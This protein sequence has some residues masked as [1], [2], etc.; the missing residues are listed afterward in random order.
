MSVVTNVMITG[1]ETGRWVDELNHWLDQRDDP[2]G[3]LLQVD[4]HCG[5]PKALET[6]VFLAA[7]NHF[8]TPAF[9]AKCRETYAQHCMWPE[10]VQLYIQ[11][12]EENRWRL[13]PLT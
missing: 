4:Q 13:I 9:I 3:N 5:G 8:D 2:P 6:E 7:F 12:Q 10:D 11:Q 1:L